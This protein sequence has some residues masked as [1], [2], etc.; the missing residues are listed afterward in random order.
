MKDEL[1]ASYWKRLGIL[2]TF[3]VFV[4]PAQATYGEQTAPSGATGEADALLMAP[5]PTMAERM[6]SVIH[7]DRPVHFTTSEGGPLVVPVGT[8]EVNAIGAT[9]LQL[10][11][12]GGSAFLIEAL[13]M[14]H[15]DTFAEAVALSIPAGEDMHHVVLLL[16]NGQ[17]L[18]AVGSYSAVRPRG[19]NPTPVLLE[20]I[21]KA[22]KQKEK[23]IRKDEKKGG[24]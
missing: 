21:E 15:P 7:L 17:G 13:I 16:P 19:W 23:P 8:Y 1:I 12:E 22:F 10:T 18:D 6:P 11:S 2:V 14:H 5:T 20:L 9:A 3:L 24:H 4:L